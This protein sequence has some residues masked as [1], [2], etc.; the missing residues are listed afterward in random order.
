MSSSASTNTADNV[1]L[2]PCSNG[3]SIRFAETDAIEN[4]NPVSYLGDETLC[5]SNEFF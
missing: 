3:E 4:P 1:G 2:V 5:I